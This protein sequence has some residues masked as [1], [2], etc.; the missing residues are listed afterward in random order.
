MTRQRRHGRAQLGRRAS[1]SRPGHLDVEQRDVG[2]ASSAAATTSSPR[3]TCATT[4]R[5][6]S[7]AE[8]RGERATDERLVLGEQHRGSS[9]RPHRDVTRSRKP[10]SGTGAGLDLAAELRATPLAEPG[11]AAAGRPARGRRRRRR[12][13]SPAS[14]VDDLD[15]VAAARSASP[16]SAARPRAVAEDVRHA[17]ADRPAE[18]GV[19]GRAAALGRGLHATVDPGRGERRPRPGQLDR[20]RWPPVAR[21]RSRGPTPAPRARPARRPRSRARARAGIVVG[22]SRR[23]S[24]LLSAI[25]DRLWPE[26]VVEVAGDPDPLLGDGQPRRARGAPPGAPGWPGRATTARTA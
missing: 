7:S 20:E 19:D 13:A 3:P 17:L 4:S 11:Q 24:S 6:G 22:S 9:P 8:Q 1:P 14:V 2:R 10:P 25:S 18:H 15:A 5:S 21:R 16:G 23:A 26:R 12:A